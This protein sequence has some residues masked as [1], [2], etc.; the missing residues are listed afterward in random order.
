MITVIAII[1]VNQGKGEDFIREYR[2]VLP[3]VLKDPGAAAY[4]LH[5][6]LKNQDKFYFY[7]KYAD[8]KAVEYHT[9]TLHFKEFFGS[10]GPYMKGQP[11]IYFCQEI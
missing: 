1:E 5:R 8:Q 10:T 6:D 7:E 11:Q 3:K 4:I 9:S 2:K